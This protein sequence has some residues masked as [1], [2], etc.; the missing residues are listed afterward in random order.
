[1]DV[2]MLKP[3]PSRFTL[4]D[5]TAVTEP[6]FKLRTNPRQEQA[7]R[8]IKQ[9][10]KEYV[11]RRETYGTVLTTTCAVFESTQRLKKENSFLMHST[12]TLDLAS[13][14]QMSNT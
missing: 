11:C 12:F 7:Y 13:R 2:S 14:M 1:M 10:F 5:L 3:F 6:V 9:W 4:P 8:N